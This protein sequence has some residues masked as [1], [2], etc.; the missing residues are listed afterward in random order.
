METIVSITGPTASGKSHV[1]LSLAQALNAEIVNA[2][3]IQVY[4]YFDI[5]SAKPTADELKKVPHHLISI[6]EPEEEF[7]AGRFIELADQAIADILWRKKSAFVVGGTGLYIKAL[8]HGLAPVSEVNC[9]THERLKAIEQDISQSYPATEFKAKLHER[10]AQFDPRAAAE[11]KVADISRIRRALTVFLA[12][13]RSVKD[14][15][16]EHKFKDAR[17][18]ALNIIVT[19]PREELYGRIDTRVDQML[20]LDWIDEVENLMPDYEESKPM[21]SIGY[22]QIV[23]YINREIAREEMIELIKQDTRHYAKRQL[24]WWRNE[25]RKLGWQSLDALWAEHC[26]GHESDNLTGRLSSFVNFY[27][28]SAPGFEAPGVS[29]LLLTS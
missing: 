28:Q 5:G 18:R 14:F 26:R 27:L 20:A 13:G 24:T 9:T 17:Y 25:P 12:T 22:K 29:Y 8:L 7:Q 23:R 21:K 1:A 4:K 2:D 6:L 3:S 11:L 10:L 16:E 19:L 15:Q